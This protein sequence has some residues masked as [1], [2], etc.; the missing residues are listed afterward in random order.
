MR[1]GR[2]TGWTGTWGEIVADDGETLWVGFRCIA[3]PPNERGWHN[4][5]GGERVTY[6]R[7][8]DKWRDYDGERSRYRHK[9]VRVKRI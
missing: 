5:D 2:I 9:A 4:F 6:K 3:D 8:R 7:K 1:H